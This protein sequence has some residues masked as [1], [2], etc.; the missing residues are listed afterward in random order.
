[1]RNIFVLIALVLAAA[2]AHAGQPTGQGAERPKKAIIIY[3]SL[4]NNTRT[5]AEFI[6][7]NTGF[8]MEEIE[9][10]TPYTAHYEELVDQTRDELERGYLP[11]LKPVKADLNSYDMI[12]VGSPLWIYTL[13][14]PVMSFLSEYD[15]SG[16]IVVPFCT[17][18]TSPAGPLFAK[19]AKLCP[20]SRVLQGFDITRG[21]Y[22]ASLPALRQWIS[23]VVSELDK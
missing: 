5:M 17:R 22:H 1:M 16:K 18:G 19:V 20:N 11:P 13:S 6:R 2:T 9:L 14:L 23:S 12:L 7:E 10:V 8:D 21:R 3:Y 15:L 4:T